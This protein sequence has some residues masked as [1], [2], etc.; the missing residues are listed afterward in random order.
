[1]ANPYVAPATSYSAKQ[2]LYWLAPRVLFPPILAWDLTKIGFNRLFGKFAGK[3]VLLAQDPV[4]AQNINLN[5]AMLESMIR[6]RPTLNHEIIDF[7]LHDDVPLE[8]MEISPVND[9]TPVNQKQYIINCCGNMQSYQQGILSLQKDALDTN[10]TVIGFNYRGV[11]NEKTGEKEDIYSTST[12]EMVDCGIAQVQRLLDAG[13]PSTN[14]MLKGISLG[15]GAANLIA[16]HFH[17]KGLP[18]YVFNLQSFSSLTN[19]LVGGIRAA[20]VKGRNGSEQPSGREE[21]LGG[22][23]LGYIAKPFIKFGL[24]VIKWEIE[25]ADAFKAIPE[26][27]K[28]Y[29][30]IRTPKAQ[31][32]PDNTLPI[33]D[34]VI[35]HYGSL[36]VALKEQR[37][38][39]NRNIEETRRNLNQCAANGTS[40]SLPALQKANQQLTEAKTALKERK[41]YDPLNPNF[42]LHGTSMDDLVYSRGSITSCGQTFFVKFTQRSFDKPELSQQ[43]VAPH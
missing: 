20:E 43:V 16:L 2:W 12:Q 9:Q 13:V 18:V 23:I 21:T 14:I 7:K 22:K 35:T 5:S 28:E 4:N 32:P 31:L 34:A 15:G 27:F 40:L 38:A 17:E 30:L 36:H 41:M 42:E 19:V 8:T 1:M 3:M 26:E 6:R 39:F 11:Y 10:K 37:K 29:A 33:D 24:S 25:S